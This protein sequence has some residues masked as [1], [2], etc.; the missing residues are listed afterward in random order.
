MSLRMSSFRYAKSR[1]NL[2]GHV[3]REIAKRSIPP[4][5][6][7][8]SGQGRHQLNL[9]AELYPDQA[10]LLQET[11]RTTHDVMA[12]TEKKVLLNPQI[13][14]S[15]QIMARAFNLP[16]AH[17]AHFVQYL[18]H[19][20]RREEY[21]AKLL[22][23]AD[24]YGKSSHEELRKKAK[25]LK[26]AAIKASLQH[27]VIGALEPYKQNLGAVNFIMHTRNTWLIADNKN[28][29]AR[30]V[31]RAK[32]KADRLK[33]PYAK[34]VACQ[35]LAAMSTDDVEK[36]NYIQQSLQIAL[37]MKRS[38]KKGER[39]LDLRNNAQ[40]VPQRNEVHALL[41]ENAP[42]KTVLKDA[43]MLYGYR[44]NEKA[45]PS[46]APMMALSM[47]ALESGQTINRHTKK[48]WQDN[49]Y[50]FSG[51]ENYLPVAAVTAVAP[52]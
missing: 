42:Y 18:L 20:P 34:S 48:M 17:D 28:D 12:I 29:V 38:G 40:T 50:K 52:A 41:V 32:R 45:W 11:G 14:L 24:S 10:K 47:A 2:P 35:H 51:M 43:E 22:S 33:N 1:S 27:H 30:D 39:L 37:V 4:H 9:Y 23:S 26:R 31:A 5:S 13:K 3:Q 8:L 15:G 25:P 7:T 49:K 21:L 36:N 46:V 19:W 44:H 16:S 6:S